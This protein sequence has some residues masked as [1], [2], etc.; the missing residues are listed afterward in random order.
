[1]TRSSSV[2]CK[3]FA[4][5]LCCATVYAETVVVPQNAENVPGDALIGG[6]APTFPFW[7]N[8]LYLA[9]DF[10]SHRVEIS[11]LRFR[12]DQAA[13]PSFETTFTDARFQLGTFDL[14]QNSLTGNRIENQ[15]NTFNLRTVYNSH[16]T[17]STSGSDLELRAF[18]YVMDFEVPY[19]YD[20]SDGA[21][22]VDFS[23]NGMN[24]PPPYWDA[25]RIDPVQGAIFLNGG[26]LEPRFPVTQV[27]IN[28]SP[29]LPLQ[30][31]LGFN[32]S[33]EIV[34]DDWLFV[35]PTPLGVARPDPARTIRVEDGSWNWSIQDEN[36][37][38][39]AVSPEHTLTDSSVETTFSYAGNTGTS[40]G[41]INRFGVTL[42]EDSTSLAHGYCVLVSNETI[43]L[44]DFDF[45]RQPDD[46][47]Q[48][49]A[50]ESTPEGLFVNDSK[51][52]ALFE[53]IDGPANGDLSKLVPK[54]HFSLNG[55]VVFDG[56]EDLQEPLNEGW[57]GIDVWSV[58]PFS[59]NSAPT[60]IAF[61]S[62][63]IRGIPRG[64]FDRS[65]HF[66][67]ADI[68][69]LSFA[70]RNE[71]ELHNSDLNKDGSVDQSDRQ[72]WLH[73]LAHTYFGDANL[74]GEFNSTDFVVVFDAGEYEDGI[75]VNS[76]WAT[77]DWNGDGEFDSG[78]FISAFQDGGYE[79]G[80]RVEV[81]N[82]PEV[83]STWFF[84][85]LGCVCIRRLV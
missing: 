75:E 13:P 43:T 48:V 78:D 80:P 64:D 45:A 23:S 84:L 25:Q 24:G 53:V 69:L 49:L 30:E 6:G 82:V 56:V 21:L 20:P 3:V 77:G 16:W 55:T 4:A 28:D 26:T 54:F 67:V 71:T 51:T 34:S 22:F 29:R 27:V 46:Y 81:A 14:P 36:H 68:D 76:T 8:W 42:D 52:T 72:Y 65:G 11:S 58:D 63:L 60:S 40:V 74:D 1:M 62:L 17:Q 79:T 32:D 59:E 33:N 70:V 37:V 18:D 35:S 15:E 66:N 57:S 41:F 38:L 7:F 31:S 47:I 10:P 19:L 83:N 9:D 61:D 2:I 85:L 5:L 12:P 44:I 73:D 39:V 50:Q